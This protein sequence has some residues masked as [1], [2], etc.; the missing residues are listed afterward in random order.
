MTTPAYEKLGQ[1]YLGKR[2]DLET[3]TRHEDLVLVDAKDYT[4]HAVI[5][6]MTG[7]GKTGLGVGML[8]EAAIDHIPVIAIDPKGDLGNIALT[9]PSLAASDF[10]P[11][12][13][14][15]QATA[16]GLDPDGFADAQ[17][18]LWAKGL[19][20]WGQDG[21]RIQRLRDAAD[22]AIY[23]PGSSA[24]RPLS[25]LRGFAA[26]PPIVRQDAEAFAERVNAT[27]TGLLALLGIDADP[28]T[29]R[30][31]IL[32]ANL[33]SH[34][35]QQGQDL[36]LPALIGAIQQ[37]PF[38][39][40][41]VMPVD[42]VFPAK[43]RLGLAMRLNNLLAAP[44][45]QAWM[46]GDPLD[47]AS[48]LYTPAGKPRVSVVSIA[49]LGDAERM[50]FV[51]MLLADIIAWMRQQP[52]TGS[53]RAILYIDELF[54]YMPPVAN[55]PSKMLLLT[56]LK[57]AR[58][59]GLG[60][61][62][63]TQNPV[64]LDYKGLS[65]TGLWFIGRLQ[66][67]RD[68]A[69]VMDGLAGAS[70]GAPFDQAAMERTI[71]GLGKRVF[72]MHSVHEN[73]PTTFETRWAMSYLAGPMTRE[74]IRRLGENTGATA[75][76]PSAAAVAPAAPAPLIPPLAAASDVAT[77]APILPV[78]IVQ[79][80][81]P[82]TAGDS[83]T[84]RPAVLGVADVSYENA[85]LGVSEQERQ[86]YLCDLDDGVLALDWNA[87]RAVD[88]DVNALERAPQAGAAFASVPGVAAA[89]KSYPTWTRALQKFI[90]SSAGVTLWQCKGLKLTSHVGETEGAFRARLQLAAREASDAKLEAVRRKYATRVNSAQEKV[91]KAEVAIGVQEQK[92][93]QAKM[94]S[95]LTIGSAVLGALFG[96]K[97]LSATTLGK[98][99]TAA[100]SMG[101][102]SARGDDVERA[103]Q[104]FE[105]AQQE[106]VELEA[107]IAEELALEEAAFDA[108]AE[109]LDE[110]VIRPKSTGVQVQVVALA[111]VPDDNA[112]PSR[113]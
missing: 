5:I 86:T 33:L 59:F 48:L 54:G 84:W 42:T 30:E 88:V 101:R 110:V 39:Q 3:R 102:A 8:E 104:T 91:R 2:Y 55:P 81:F 22:V 76:A 74:Q 18:S 23:T 78:E 10:R 77:S 72:L 71:S 93:S 52:G 29:S 111:W 112:P 105:A 62:M 12:I 35:W 82:S 25:L 108:L 28:I 92:A 103:R 80:W 61:I 73:A 44:G 70:G 50:F 24:G 60:V 21:A 89:P 85:K 11:W 94:D 75:S 95:A 41:G 100:R 4:T 19:A 7:S 79:V 96:R 49:H 26:P 63:A 56:L 47:T 1:F 34:A 83:A 97:K 14:P 99:G 45:F 66:T 69:R 57:Q 98:A 64:D 16:A 113:A 68:K 67:E 36:D 53:L 9:F 32:L 58:A 20:S 6:G 65:N 51:T 90:A 107:R 27:A 13:D 109:Q 40:I 87:A 43:D 15:Q 17:A 106:L 46:Q 38:A 31:H 37:P